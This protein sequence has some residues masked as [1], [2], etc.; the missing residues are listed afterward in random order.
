M[1]FPFDWKRS[2]DFLGSEWLLP[3]DNI[4]WICGFVGR[5]PLL[6]Q[7][8]R[9]RRVCTPDSNAGVGFAGAG[10]NNNS[11]RYFVPQSPGKD[12]SCHQ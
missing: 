3:Y 6:E 1:E 5:V 12:D 9:T 2:D 10:C 8:V 11:R 4:R 7:I